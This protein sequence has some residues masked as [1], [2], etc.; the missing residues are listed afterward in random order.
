MTNLFNYIDRPS[1]IHRLTGASKLVCLLAWSGAAMTSFYTPLLLALTVGA[2]ALFHVAKL[3]YRDVSDC[4]L[5]V[6]DS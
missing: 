2:F 6:F 4:R 1:P 3:R 5:E